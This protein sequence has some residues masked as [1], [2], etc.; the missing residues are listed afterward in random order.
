[1]TEQ[2]ITFTLPG[3]PIP[4]HRSKQTRTN[5][6]DGRHTR[7]YKDQKDVAYQRAIS[8]HA[9]HA[10]QLWTQ[11]FKKPW[12]P[13]G[14]WELECEFNVGDLVK[15]DVDNL[16]KQVMDALS[17]VAYEDDKQVCRLVVTKRLNRKKPSSIVTLRRVH[18]YLEE[19]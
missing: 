2:R 7:F 4:W 13:S 16:S 3:K 14:E 11:S 6:L 9:M 1:V 17:G 12:D 19:H 10:L 8:M 18:G 15:K 5:R